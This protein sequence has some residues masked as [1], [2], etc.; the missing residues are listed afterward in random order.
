MEVLVCHM[1][2]AK[3]VKFGILPIFNV[4]VQMELRIMEKF[5]FLVQM[6]RFGFLVKVVSVQKENLILDQNVK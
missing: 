2:N 5:V 1:L 6:K 4:H 3:M